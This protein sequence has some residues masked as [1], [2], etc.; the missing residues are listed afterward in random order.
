MLQTRAHGGKLKFIGKIIP[1]YAM[2]HSVPRQKHSGR[3]PT[4]AAKSRVG[5]AYKPLVAAISG[6]F[7]TV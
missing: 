3:F 2:S 1:K 7:S 4:P 5:A 6:I